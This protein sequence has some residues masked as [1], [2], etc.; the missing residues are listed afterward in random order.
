MYPCLYAKGD[1]TAADAVDN[2]AAEV[3][4]GAP[5]DVGEVVDIDLDDPEVEVAASRIQAGY[6]GM[7]TRKELAGAGRGRKDAK[8]D[9]DEDVAAT[10]VGSC[11]LALYDKGSPVSKAGIPFQP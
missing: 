5:V 2:D 9:K 3:A 11:I 7:K 6:K 4:G 1:G 8:D 10:Q